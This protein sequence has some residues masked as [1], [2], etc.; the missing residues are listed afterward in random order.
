MQPDNTCPLCA[1]RGSL[2]IRVGDGINSNSASAMCVSCFEAW[3]DSN[4]GLLANHIRSENDD[5]PLL[6]ESGAA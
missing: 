6:Y 2:R 1:T 4:I 5:E 3:D